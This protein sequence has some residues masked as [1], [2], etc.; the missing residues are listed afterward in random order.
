MQNTK[1]AINM[2]DHDSKISCHV[3]ENNNEMDFGRVRVI[4]HEANFHVQLRLEAWMSI[5]DPQVFGMRISLTLCFFLKIHG[6]FFPQGAF[7]VL[8]FESH[9]LMLKF[10]LIHEGSRTSQNILNETSKN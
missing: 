9:V 8:F 5:K 6:R 7:E 1:R 3:N 10:Q 4:G 2:L